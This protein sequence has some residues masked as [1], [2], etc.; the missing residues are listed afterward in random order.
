VKPQSRSVQT[1]SSTARRGAAMPQKKA[2]FRLRP[3]DIAL[4][5]GLL[6][7][8]GF[9]IWGGLNPNT[10]TVASVPQL[11]NTTP[12]SQG[13][14]APDFTLPGTDSKTYSLSDYKG[15]V[16]MIEFMAP[17]CPHCQ[18]DAPEFN[19]LYETYKDKGVQ[20]LGVSATAYGKDYNQT[21]KPPITMEDMVWFKD[22]FK[23]PYPMLLDKELKAAN[24][25]GIEYYPTAYIIDKNGNVFGQ[26]TADVDKPMNAETLSPELDKALALK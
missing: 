16:V 7:V 4:T 23:V 10:G 19:K 3:L 9:I 24:A 1:G 25:Y 17:W 11:N 12:V 15:K 26:Y 13:N 20:M 14:G 8:V 2:G 6:A 18:A 21:N 22:T 5:L